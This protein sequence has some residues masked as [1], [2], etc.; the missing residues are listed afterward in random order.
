MMT[1]KMTK[2]KSNSPRRNLK[3]RMPIKLILVLY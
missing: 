2:R 1:M 3:R